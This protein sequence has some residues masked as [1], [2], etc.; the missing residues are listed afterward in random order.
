MLNL[1]TLQLC[2]KGLNGRKLNTILCLFEA[3]I[4]LNTNYSDSRVHCAHQTDRFGVYCYVPFQGLQ[5][6]F[7]TG[8]KDTPLDPCP[9]PEE[10]MKRKTSKKE[11]KGKERKKSGEKGRNKRC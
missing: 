9:E 7:G 3:H 6:L 10:R 8:M 2:H 5:S 11:R 4:T 1:H